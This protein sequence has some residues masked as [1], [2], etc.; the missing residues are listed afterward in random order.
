MELKEKA[1]KSIRWNMVATI[2]KIFI[3]LLRIA[4][5]TRFIDAANFGLVAIASMVIAFTD[6]F[7]DLGITVGIIH[8]QDITQEEYSSLFWMNLMFSSVLFIFVCLVS[9]LVA[10]F[11]HEPE[12]KTII[13]ILAIQ[14]L[15]HAF[16]KIFQTIKSKNLEFDFLSKVSII[17]STIGFLSSIVFAWMG[18][19]V[20]SLVYSQLLLVAICQISYA[21]AGSK[22]LKIQTHFK[23]SDVSDFIKIGLYKLGSGILDFVSE[24]IDIFLI[25]HFFTMDDLGIYNLAKE[26]IYR[27]YQIIVSLVTNVA[28]ATF[29]KIQN[30]INAVR[31]N[32]LRMLRIVGV[33]T[34]LIYAVM[35]VF[36]DAV[37][38]VLYAPEFAGTSFFIRVLSICGLLT[39]FD[40]MSSPIQTSYGRTDL[41]FVWTIIRI[42]LSTVV[43]V[44]TGMISV[45]AVAYGQVVVSV[46]SYIL[47]FLF[48]VRKLVKVNFR[49]YVM[50]P[51]PP[52]I[53]SVVIGAPFIVL[54]ALFKLNLVVQLVFAVVFVIIYILYYMHFEHDFFLSTIQFVFGEKAKKLVGRIHVKSVF[55]HN[56]EI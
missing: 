53:L 14:I 25:G 41:G 48:V 4:I 18:W 51:L 9:P 11:Y 21:V 29:A 3:Q 5:L 49:E 56:D 28:A 33:I 54:L 8:K 10:D 23:F 34:S 15:L 13:P 37:A 1:A 24:K 22:T 39:C 6:I 50:I 12:L 55:T 47:F 44:I 30:N 42:I 26:L 45:N 31:G 35:F 20:Y 19:G 32:F 46:V 38:A 17:S 27:P 16:G 40:S 36:S 52:V 7:A 2:Y 43:L